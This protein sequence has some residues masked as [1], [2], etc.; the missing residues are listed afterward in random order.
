MSKRKVT[1]NFKTK[2]MRLPIFIFI[3]FCGFGVAAQHLYRYGS[4]LTVMED[5]RALSMPWA[6]GVNAAQIQS[7]D[8]TGD[9]QEEYVVWDINARQVNVFSGQSG[10]FTHF[11]ELS[12]YFPSDI[13]GFM[14]LADYDG[15]GRKDLFTSSPFGIKAYRNVTPVGANAPEWEVAQEFLRLENGSNVTA[16]SLDIPLLIDID[17]DGDLDLLT[18]NFATGDYL[19]YYKNT[20]MERKGERDIDAFSRAQ[21]RWGGFEFCG[22]GNISFGLTCSGQPIATAPVPLPNFRVEHAGGHSMLYTDLNGDGVRDL[23]MGQDE[24][25]VLYFLPNKGT[26]EAPVFDSFENNLPGLGPLPEFPIFHAANLVKDQLFIS[27][28]SSEASLGPGIDFGSSILSYPFP[29]GDAP[30]ISRFFQSDMLDLGENA[31]PFFQGSQVSGNLVISSNRTIQG[32]VRSQ[33]SLYR[34]E[35]GVFTELEQDFLGLSEKALREMSYQEWRTSDGRSLHIVTGDIVEN[36]IPRKRIFWRPTSSSPG[37]FQSSSVTGFDLRGVDHLHFFSHGEMDYLLLGRQ[38]G[39]L[40]LMRVRLAESQMDFEVLERDFLGFSD[41][42]VNRALTATVHLG[43][44]PSLF[45]VD[46]RGM[47]FVV[48]DFLNASSGRQ[49]LILELPGSTEPVITRLGRNSWITPI[50]DA[51]G[52]KVDLIIGTRAGGLVYLED[53]GFSSSIPGE[54]GL[55]L[56]IFPN[57]TSDAITVLSNADAIGTL[58]GVNGQ[59]I[60]EGLQVRQGVEQRLDLMGLAPGVYVLR[61]FSENRGS[62]AKKILFRP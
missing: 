29:L 24:C 44:T 41:N 6:G 35:N 53:I 57:P 33:A 45:A 26:D 55:R 16:N 37:D 48:E 19:E 38:T 30:P 62:V 9:G 39:E 11:P 59:I 8:V 5:G 17:G 3:M 23:L 61:L 2:N 27:S 52:E 58:V 4:E 21:I 20:S 22:C 13:S 12:H 51:F 10:D 31:R 25:S 18:F 34:L 7:M 32:R 43:T 15:D 54:E 1:F 46:Q 14:V 56:R 40:V 60:M 50:P 49:E 36:N 42:P 47:L 28:H